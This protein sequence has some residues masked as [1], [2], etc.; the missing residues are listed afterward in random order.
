MVVNRTLA[1]ALLRRLGFE[2]SEV[3]G[4]LAALEWINSH[5][6]V[7]LVLLDIS[8]P[9]LC[10]E[11]VCKRLRSIPAN[12]GLK[13]VAYTAHAGQDD[14]DRFLTN[15]F[16]AVLIKPISMKLLTEVVAKLF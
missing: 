9:D 4:G 7:N 12:A 13:I 5:V 14:A 3:D 11:E 8:M 2:T 6:P 15:G 10:G 16:D 1:V